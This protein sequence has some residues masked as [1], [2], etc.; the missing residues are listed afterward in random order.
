VLELLLSYDLAGHSL[1]HR[2]L[3]LLQLLEDIEMLFLELPQVLL[4]NGVVLLEFC[5]FCLENVV[6][7]SKLGVLGAQELDFL[8]ELR[9]FGL[10][11][12]PGFGGIGS[13]TFHHGRVLPQ[14][15]E[16][17]LVLGHDLLEIG[18]LLLGLYKFLSQALR[19]IV[20]GRYLP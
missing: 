12:I 8:G 5:I 10:R 19:P 20:R 11:S 2:G 18:I 15:S 7:L 9:K 4:E 16:V 13:L 1:L 14:D 17:L 6:I 3:A